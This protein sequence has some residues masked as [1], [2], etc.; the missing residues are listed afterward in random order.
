MT[1]A[2]GST[3]AKD[4]AHSVAL[5]GT[6]APTTIL[7]YAG[8]VILNQPE[9]QDRSYDSLGMLRG[10]LSGYYPL[11]MGEASGLSLPQHILRLLHTGTSVAQ[12]ENLSYFDLFPTLESIKYLRS[13]SAGWN[14]Y[15]I[16]EP[17]EAA[18]EEALSWLT[19]LY[20]EIR[21]T[22][23]TWQA[24]SV[25]ADENG[26]IVLEWES[27]DNGLTFYI[28]GTDI[29]YLLDWGY[30]TENEMEYG[31]LTDRSEISELWERWNG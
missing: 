23:Y 12:L 17:S 9:R 2:F 5:A 8:S 21:S 29:S 30:D 18:I 3:K 14:G 10:Q 27:G 15:N 26:S 7:I 24:P 19:V 16:P 13:L 1:T 20:E 31:E 25:S 4:F 28:S 11:R 22:P 6:P